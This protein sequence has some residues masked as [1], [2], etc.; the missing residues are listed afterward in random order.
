MAA[1]LLGIGMGASMTTSIFL[2]A[3]EAD[4]PS[5]PPKPPERGGA[6]QRAGSRVRP[7]ARR[8]PSGAP[9]LD[10]PRH[11]AASVVRRG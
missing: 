7:A 2:V 9:A 8:S 11:C 10:G 3:D 6:R 4:Q 5:M 1:D